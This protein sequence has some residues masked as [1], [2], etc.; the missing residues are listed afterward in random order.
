MIASL[1]SRA[2]GSAFELPLRES[3]PPSRIA[4]AESVTVSIS[5]GETILNMEMGSLSAIA[6]ETVSMTSSG[7]A[8]PR[9]VR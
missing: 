5:D 3:E 6:C 1:D 4:S 7:E 8:A 9:W 2:P